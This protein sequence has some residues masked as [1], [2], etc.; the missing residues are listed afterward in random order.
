L[1]S[2]TLRCIAKTNIFHRDLAEQYDDPAKHIATNI[3]RT[4]LPKIRSI[5]K[6]NSIYNMY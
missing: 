1:S 3:H 4:D 5:R 6:N 2:D